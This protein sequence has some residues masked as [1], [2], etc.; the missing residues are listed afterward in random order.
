MSPL[1]CRS[2]HTWSIENCNTFYHRF[3]VLMTGHNQHTQP[4]A[5]FHYLMLSDLEMY[6]LV[7]KTPWVL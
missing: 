6:W 4:R 1:A 2:V 7:E 5:K 3:R